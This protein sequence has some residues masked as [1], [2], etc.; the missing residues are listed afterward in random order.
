MDKSKKSGKKKTSKAKKP[1]RRK[2]KKKQIEKITVISA[3]VLA[4]VGLLIWGIIALIQKKDEPKNSY[5]DYDL[6][7]YIELKQLDPIRAPFAD[8]EVC[9][10]DEIDY[11]IH[12]VMLSHSEFTTKEA[13][14][15]V[16]TY[17]RV[18]VDYKVFYEGEA[19]DE[20]C[21][22]QY[23][24]IIGYDGNGDEALANALVGKKVGD[25]C[26]VTNTVAADDISMGAW[27][28]AT[29]QCQ[30]TILEIQSSLVPVCTDEFVQQL[31]DY[32][33]VQD[34]RVH[35]KESLKE[36]KTEA[37]ASLVLDAFLA[38]VVVKKYPEEMVKKY[39]EEYITEIKAMAEDLG[40]TYEEYV[41]EYLQTTVDK[42]NKMSL[43]DARERVKNDMA[44]IQAGRL[45]KVEVSE[46]EYR[47][48]L[49]KAWEVKKEEFKT[50]E[51]FE[52]HYTKEVLMEAI[53]FDKT[54]EVMMKNAVSTLEQ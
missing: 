17:D 11:A 10:E 27:A 28:G 25:V 33:D 32:A 4:A 52:K 6:S 5:Y 42:I 45:L 14:A 19:V 51:E 8:P 30:G 13:G 50:V 48:G 9:T 53:R 38:G 41:S 16:E 54:F 18:I 15:V 34:F 49:E 44:H 24:L 29:L 1:F 46:K 21:Q 37:K 12:Q 36:Q 43:E 31:G 20:F 3:C 2:L 26:T 22:P 39:V 40:I 35:V 47:E 7:E 23:M